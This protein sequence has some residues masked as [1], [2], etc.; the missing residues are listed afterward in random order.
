MVLLGAVFRKHKA[1]E[2]DDETKDHVIIINFV[3][4]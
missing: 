2:L 1:K 3:I 4:S